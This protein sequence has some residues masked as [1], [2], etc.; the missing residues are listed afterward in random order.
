MPTYVLIWLLI[1]GGR[2]ESNDHEYEGELA[3]ETAKAQLIKEFSSPN[4]ELH[5]FC[6]KKRT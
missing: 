5:V 2:T 1:T 3:C 6:S 4:R